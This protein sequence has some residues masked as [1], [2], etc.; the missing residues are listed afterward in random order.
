MTAILLFS[1]VIHVGALA[2]AMVHVMSAWHA[3]QGQAEL[4]P[5][6]TMRVAVYFGLG[7]GAVAAILM[8]IA[9]PMGPALATGLVAGMIA[10]IL[11]SLISQIRPTA[12]SLS[13][14]GWHHRPQVLVFYG[15]F[16]L[17]EVLAVSFLV[18]A[19]AGP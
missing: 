17:L 5:S 19:L 13:G 10:A 2:L 9:H 16:A 7:V 12:P 8:R 1:A 14:L 4:T 3:S 18:T 11:L 15:T 6:E